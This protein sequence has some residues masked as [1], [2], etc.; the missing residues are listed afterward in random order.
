ME[1]GTVHNWLEQGARQH[2]EMNENIQSMWKVEV[3]D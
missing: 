2:V 3:V 1:L